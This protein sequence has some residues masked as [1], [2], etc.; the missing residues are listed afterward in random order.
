MTN[1]EASYQ[2]QTEETIQLEISSLLRELKNFA[3][4]NRR[5]KNGTADS[6][7][8]V[9]VEGEKADDDA[10]GF[11]ME[12]DEPESTEW[13]DEYED[14]E[15]CA[16][17]PTSEFIYTFKAE[18][19]REFREEPWG[20]R[21]FAWLGFMLSVE[22]IQND[23]YMPAHLAEGVI[24]LPAEEA[25]REIGPIACRSEVRFSMNTLTKNFSLCESSTYLDL[26]GDPLCDIPCSCVEADVR[27]V[28]LEEPEE[29]DGQLV[30][31]DA[32][33][34][35]IASS[36]LID[37]SLHEASDYTDIDQAVGEWRDMQHIGE[38]LDLEVRHSNVI[39]AR[40][41]LDNIQ[42]V[43]WTQAGL[44]PAEQ[45]VLKKRLRTR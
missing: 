40:R 16:I 22:A 7:M 28:Q 30:L 44:T 14:D 2:E 3:N 32:S 21:P 34:Q 1:P 45:H 10:L 29:V 6:V 33:P 18:R 26:D 12:Y 27:Y 4:A 25:V 15:D 23:V 24:D 19:I 11:F 5:F 39:R 37:K 20:K 13:D 17:I 9:A 31:P 38:R 8:L 43:I 36:A 42:N 35:Q 41:T